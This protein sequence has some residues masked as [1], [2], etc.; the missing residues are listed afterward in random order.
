MQ[1]GLESGVMVVVDSKAMVGLAVL[2]SGGVGGVGL[3]AVWWWLWAR[4]R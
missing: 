4:K 2:E 1:C 3:K